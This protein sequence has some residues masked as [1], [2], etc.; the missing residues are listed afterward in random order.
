MEMRVTAPAKVNWHLQV[1]E[2]RAD[3]FHEIVSLFQKINL[4]D[5]LY[6]SYKE[7]SSFSFSLFGLESVCDKGKST[8]DKA[9]A[10]WHEA[11]G[12]NAE[13]SVTIEKNIPDK[14]GL[15][16]GSSDAA[17]LLVSLERLAGFPSSPLSLLRIAAETGSDVPF[18]IAGCD[19]AIVTGRGEFVM[20]VEARHDLCGYLL[21]PEGKKVSTKEAYDA[22][23]SRA[24]FS[25]FL[26]ESDILSIYNKPVC[27]W[28]FENDFTAVNS[29]PCIGD[30]KKTLLLTGSGS[31]WLVVSDSVFDK[32][33]LDSFQGRVIDF[34]S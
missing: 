2:K 24:S 8:L 6:I 7:A 3:G 26:H 15:G 12:I 1:G 5:V 11:T 30:C 10:L 32:K 27:E 25:G 34:K 4:C 18:F 14:S 21:I 13:V 31:C 33:E 9:A 23:D 16:G 19:A 28:N 29:A 20:P 22:I 17:S